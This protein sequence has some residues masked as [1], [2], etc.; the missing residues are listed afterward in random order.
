MVENGDDKQRIENAEIYAREDI[1]K[2]DQAIERE[3]IIKEERKT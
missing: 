3:P 2:Y 1:R